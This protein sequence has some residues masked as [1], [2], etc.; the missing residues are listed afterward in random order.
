MAY[1]KALKSKIRAEYLIGHRSKTEICEGRAVT[2]GKLEGKKN[3]PMKTLL[4]WAAKENWVY[5]SGEE[6]VIKKVT[7]E[8]TELIEQNMV[9]DLYGFTE[10]FI[11]S[12][13]MVEGLTKK[14]MSD[15]AKKLTSGT[16]RP[17]DTQASLTSQRYLK[18]TASTL[19][20]VYSEK[21][22]ALGLDKEQS[23]SGSVNINTAPVKIE[24]VGVDPD[25]KR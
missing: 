8:A 4:Q 2:K 25:D 23:A 24:I 10:D 7:D 16:L 14:T 11:K 21:R 3:L 15:Y 13:K 6:K 19:V 18:E 17:A 9:N 20:L 12:A 22:K 5:G 1:P